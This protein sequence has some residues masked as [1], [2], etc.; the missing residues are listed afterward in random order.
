MQSVRRGKNVG[1]NSFK[2]HKNFSSVA[3]SVYVTSAVA[4][5]ASQIHVLSNFANLQSKFGLNCI[6]QFT[7]SRTVAHY[8]VQNYGKL[9]KGV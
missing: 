6:Y 7:L 5:R 9:F 4:V 1:E 2:L 8:N 3:L